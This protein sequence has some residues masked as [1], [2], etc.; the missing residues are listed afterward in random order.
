MADEP[1]HSRDPLDRDYTPDWA[2]RAMVDRIARVMDDAGHKQGPRTIWEPACG[3][4]AFVAASRNQW[5][6]ARILATDIDPKV[7]ENP[8]PGANATMCADLL[9]TDEMTGVDLILGNLAFKHAEEHLRYLFDQRHGVYAFLLRL[10]FLASSKRTKFWQEWPAKQL[11]VFSK[12]IAFTA[13]PWAPHAALRDGKRTD[14]QDYALMMWGDVPFRPT[15]W[16][17]GVPK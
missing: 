11:H 2:A 6:A 17:S 13:P 16:I 15:Q 8:I 1:T 14:S 10:G 4:G 5:P 12:R 9:E 3:A 7:F